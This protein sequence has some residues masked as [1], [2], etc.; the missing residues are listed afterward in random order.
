[1]HALGFRVMRLCKPNLQEETPLRLDLAT[2]LTADWQP[3]STGRQSSIDTENIP[4]ANR[5]QMRLPSDAWGLEGMLEL[6]Q[7]FGVIYL[8]EVGRAA[9]ACACEQRL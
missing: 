9:A 1:M 8:G 3:T 5:V 2:D 4:F 6:P 7:S